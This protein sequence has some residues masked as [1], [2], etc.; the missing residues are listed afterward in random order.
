MGF[1][2]LDRDT[3]M[4]KISHQHTKRTIITTTEE[5]NNYTC[6]VVNDNNNDKA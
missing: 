3:D 6:Y 5:N 1:I 2:F 4:Y